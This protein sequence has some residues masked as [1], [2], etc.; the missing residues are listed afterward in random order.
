MD[1]NEFMNWLSENFNLDCGAAHRIVGN[2]LNYAEQFS[3][4]ERY[5]ILSELLDG[6]GLEDSEIKSIRL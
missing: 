4:V 5:S 3:E 2:I 1:K 6:I